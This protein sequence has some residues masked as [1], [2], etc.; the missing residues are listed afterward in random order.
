MYVFGRTEDGNGFIEST[1]GGTPVTIAKP[2][3]DALGAAVGHFADCGMGQRGK[4]LAHAILKGFY[5]EW[6]K[7]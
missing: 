6:M 5:K 3:A 1:K 2:E 4:R 7:G